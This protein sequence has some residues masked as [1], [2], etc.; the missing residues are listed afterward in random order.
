M[1]KG[2]ATSIVLLIGIAALSGCTTPLTNFEF[3]GDKDP[4]TVPQGPHTTVILDYWILS[5]KGGSFPNSF[6][7]IECRNNC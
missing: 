6:L 1:N 4:V 3:A 2:I 5:N 7:I